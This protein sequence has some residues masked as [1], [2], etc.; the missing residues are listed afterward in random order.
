MFLGM[1]HNVRKLLGWETYPPVWG[2]VVPLGLRKALG[3]R[4]ARTTSRG[5]RSS[6]PTQRPPGHRDP[7]AL[8]GKSLKLVLKA[9]LQCA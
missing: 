2:G 6:A 9:T 8:G 5:Q 7:W 3:S 4:P 1:L